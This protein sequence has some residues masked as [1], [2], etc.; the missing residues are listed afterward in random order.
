MTTFESFKARDINRMAKQHVQAAEFIQEDMEAVLCWGI[1]IANYEV[2][3]F[4]TFISHP[5]SDAGLF[6]QW[7]WSL[8]ASKQQGIAP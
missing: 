4:W 8:A 7:C 6:A 1:R 2:M 5:T 3:I